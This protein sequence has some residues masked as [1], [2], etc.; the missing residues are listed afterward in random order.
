LLPNNATTTGGSAPY[1][2]DEIPPDTD[3]SEAEWQRILKRQSGKREKSLTAF[4][5]SLGLMAARVGE[6]DARIFLESTPPDNLCNA[7]RLAKS[8]TRYA[9]VNPAF[10]DFVDTVLERSALGAMI[11][12]HASVAMAL[13]QAHGIV[14]QDVM[15]AASSRVLSR[16][17]TTPP[18]SS[19]PAGGVAGS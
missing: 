11:A 8:V 2:R 3:L 7:Q 18:I 13:L 16:F 1:E 15:K 14:P 19:A 12:L 6:M 4:Y 10:G 17:K 5:F 9:E